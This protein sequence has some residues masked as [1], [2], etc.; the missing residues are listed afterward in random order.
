V[1]EKG[2]KGHEAWP[3]FVSHKATFVNVVLSR[4][5]QVNFEYRLD[6]GKLSE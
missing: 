6:V 2:S 4:S 1:E 3:I 5:E